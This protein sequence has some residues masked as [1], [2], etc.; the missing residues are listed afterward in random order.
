MAIF[1]FMELFS[2]QYSISQFR[3]LCNI[4][5]GIICIK[6]S[7][8]ISFFNDFC[9]SDIKNVDRPHYFMIYI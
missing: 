1:I 9:L 4:F 8:G 5:D 3:A 2:L 7:N 6:Q